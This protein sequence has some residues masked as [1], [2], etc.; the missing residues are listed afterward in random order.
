MY[1]A[2]APMPLPATRQ[3]SISLWG[4]WRIISRSLHVPGSPSSAFTTR[5]FG[6]PHSKRGK[7]QTCQQIIY[8]WNLS[9][10]RRLFLFPLAPTCHRWVCSWNSTSCLSEILLLLCHEAP[11]FSPHSGS[12][13]VPSVWSPWSYTN[14][15]FLALLWVWEKKR[16]R[17]ATERDKVFLQV[18]RE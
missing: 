6:L 17:R 5:Y 10:I 11:R 8:S 3:P 4:S 14:L 13:P 2:R 9:I 16:K 12:S 18:I 7:S 15:L 1:A